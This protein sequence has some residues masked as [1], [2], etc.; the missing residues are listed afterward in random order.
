M[1]ERLQAIL[2][3]ALKYHATDIHINTK[4]QETDIEMRIDNVMHEVRAKADDY[5]LVRYIKY[6]AN[7]DVS[8]KLI[9]QT[10]EFEMEIDGKLLK[11]RYAIIDN[12]CFSD[13]V[14][15]ILNTYEEV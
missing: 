14:L 4:F 8:R 11:L 13:S 10:S 1:D 7:M 9:P 12:E 15:R 3:L 2:R 6:L 5:K